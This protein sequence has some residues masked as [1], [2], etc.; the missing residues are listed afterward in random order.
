MK[1]SKPTPN[2]EL[3][4]TTLLVALVVLYFLVVVIIGSVMF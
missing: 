3:F 4:V 1:P 2:D